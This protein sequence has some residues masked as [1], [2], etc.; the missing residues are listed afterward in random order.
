MIKKIK[1]KYAFTMIE[2]IVVIVILAVL[3][4]VALPMLH[5]GFNAYFTQR[6]LTDNNWQGRLAFSR[7]ERDIHNIPSASSITTATATQF[8]FN[9]NTNTSVSY[10]LSG[11]N[12]QRNALT[13][14]TGVAS[15]TFEYYDSAGAITATIANI[16]YVW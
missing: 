12:F 15:V 10:T 16:R 2:L 7:L 13:L 14:A 1:N 9:D 6:D 5:A 4:V 11:T 8:T 3:S